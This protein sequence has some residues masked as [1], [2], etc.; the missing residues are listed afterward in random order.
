VRVATVQRRDAT[1]VAIV[2]LCTLMR[3][4]ASGTN[5]TVLEEHLRDA[6]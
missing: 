1:G 6:G 4:E 2:R 3:T 5:R